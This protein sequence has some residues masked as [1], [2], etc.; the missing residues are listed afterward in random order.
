VTNSK[1][2]LGAES[3]KVSKPL[4]PKVIIMIYSTMIDRIADYLDR[5]DLGT[6]A[7]SPMSSTKIGQWINDTRKDIALKYD[8]NYL[9]EEA[10]VS[11]SANSATYSLPTDY[12]GH[13]TILCDSKKLTRVGAREFD[14]LYYTEEEDTTSPSTLELTESSD[15]T[16]GFPEYYIDRGMYIQLFPEP[17]A[18][19][20][21]TMKYYAQPADF[22][23]G[24]D[25][26]YMSRFHFE[27]IIFGAAL[28]GAIYLDDSAKIDIFRLAYKMS[29]D[30]IVRREK[31]TKSKDTHVRVKSWKDYEL[32]T[33]RRL[34][35]VQNS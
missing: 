12:M 14:E 25:E 11:T 34:T 26:D 17:D 8:F 19:Y 6:S 20:T 5:T 10:T 24:D 15:A 31:D 32:S 21:I 4:I 2:L 35:R 29:I 23:T 28:R 1:I 7:S 9:Y 13:L 22:D 18:A 33:F 27:A 30:E 16:N 3:L